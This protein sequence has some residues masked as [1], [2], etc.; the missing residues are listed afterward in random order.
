MGVPA[1]YLA[2]TIEGMLVEMGHDFGHRF[3]PLTV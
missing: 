3:D 1:L 2:L